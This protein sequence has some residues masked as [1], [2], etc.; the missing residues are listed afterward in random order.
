MLLTSSNSTLITLSFIKPLFPLVYRNN[1]I[2]Q[3]NTWIPPHQ[4]IIDIQNTCSFTSLFLVQQ[5]PFY[6]NQLGVLQIIWTE[7]YIRYHNYYYF[8]NM[9]P[10]HTVRSHLTTT[11]QLTH[12][13]SF[14]YNLTFRFTKFTQIF[15][16][17]RCSI[18]HLLKIIDFLIT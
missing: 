8:F 10:P 14:I 6:T 16:S 2:T 5:S 9:N 12:P 18:I 3:L 15:P 13:S 1:V 7:S 11:C 17:D 4:S